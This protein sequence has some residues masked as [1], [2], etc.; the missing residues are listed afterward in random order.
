MYIRNVSTESGAKADDK[1]I[2]EQR[3]IVASVLQF[4]ACL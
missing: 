2:N 4:S 3:N 1:K